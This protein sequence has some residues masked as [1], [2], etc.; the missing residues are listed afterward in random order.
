MTKDFVM[1]AGVTLLN[2]G[3][4]ADK[5]VAVTLKHPRQSDVTFTE[6]GYTDIDGVA[7]LVCMRTPDTQNVVLH[8]AY[9]A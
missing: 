7:E 8:V 1:K 4:A 2:S 5:I 9:N 3:I 6:V